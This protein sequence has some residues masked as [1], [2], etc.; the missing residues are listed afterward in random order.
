V[1]PALLVETD[2]A[3]ER[4]LPRFGRP[5]GRRIVD[6]ATGPIHLLEA[7]EGP[8]VVLLHGGFGGAGSWYRTL[9]P[10]ALRCRVLAPDRPGYGLSTPDSSDA[11]D[12]LDETLAAL[13]LRRVALVGHASGGALALAYAQ[14]RPGAVTALVLSDLPLV[15]DHTPAPKAGLPPGLGGRSGTRHPE[16][17]SP[18]PRPPSP[19]VRRPPRRVETWYPSV[20][21]RF[22]DRRLLAP[23]YLY[24]LWCLARLWPGQDQRPPGELAPGPVAIPGPGERTWPTLPSLLIWGRSN[25]WTG[26]AAARQLHER[27]PDAAL[28]VIEHSKGIP[29]L[30]QPG[31]FNHAILSFLAAHLH[32]R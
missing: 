14:A 18:I 27:I 8:A 28:R 6:T 12:W 31:E 3:V 32:S 9:G 15:S 19:I 4:L 7:G 11:L 20:A 1:D 5:V 23:E 13:D 25:R 24:Y 29:S 22:D 26:V 16:P 21:T 17:R 2:A 30:E 10:L